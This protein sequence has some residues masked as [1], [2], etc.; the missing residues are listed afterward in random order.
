M[1]LSYFRITALLLPFI[2]APLGNAV[3]QAPPAPPTP[4][5]P[6]PTPAAAAARQNPTVMVVDYQALL[7]FE[8][9]EDGSQPN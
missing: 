5:P 9:G 7:E 4:A 6:S 3:A 1:F 2:C 8:G